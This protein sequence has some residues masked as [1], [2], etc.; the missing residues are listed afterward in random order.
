MRRPAVAYSIFVFIFTIVSVGLIYVVANY[1]LGFIPYQQN[2]YRADA[3][4]AMNTLWNW[5]PVIALF[6]AIIALL[7]AAQKRKVG[8]E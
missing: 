6:G 5:W 2:Y 4:T 3:Y 7:M 8:E 1:A